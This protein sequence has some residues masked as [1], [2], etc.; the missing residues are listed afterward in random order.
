[1]I[2]VVCCPAIFV[3][4]TRKSSGSSRSGSSSGSDTK[5]VVIVKSVSGSELEL[6]L[7]ESGSV[8]SRKS[9]KSVHSGKSVRSGKSRPRY[10]N[11]EDE[12]TVIEEDDVSEI[13]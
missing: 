12:I 9:G 10:N 11:P 3:C 13:I 8:I 5:S 6:D 4:I 1:M 7:V 2:L